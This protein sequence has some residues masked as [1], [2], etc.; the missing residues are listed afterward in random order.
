VGVV[1][2]EGYGLLP[3][4]RPAG[5]VALDAPPEL[6]SPTR[7]GEKIGPLPRPLP[8]SGMV[9]LARAGAVAAG[10]DGAGAELAMDGGPIR[11]D[12]VTNRP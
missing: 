2:V 1:P 5:W 12:P 9:S 11:M 8:T 3:V 4:V 7:R 10:S 6:W